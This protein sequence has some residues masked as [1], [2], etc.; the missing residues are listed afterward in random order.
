MLRAESRTLSLLGKHSTLKYIKAFF[1][2]FSNFKAS[3]PSVA[4]VSFELSLYHR[5]AL[6]FHSFDLSLWSSWNYRLEPPILAD[7]FN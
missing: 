4:K 3:S 7:I 6:N 2:I 1:F 5:L